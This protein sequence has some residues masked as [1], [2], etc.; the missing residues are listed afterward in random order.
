MWQEELIDA[1]SASLGDIGHVR[2]LFLVGSHGKGAADAFSDIDLL[3]IVEE[4]RKADFVSAWR[5]TL[6]NVTSI[7]F[8]NQRQADGILINAITAD[9]IRCDLVIP[10]GT[11]LHGR[12]R[13]TVRVLIDRDDLYGTLPAHLSHSG[14]NA[15][16]VK[17]LINE[18]IRVLGL[19][20]V[21][22]GRGEY[23]TGVAGAGMLR[24]H[25]ASLMVEESGITDPGGA[26]HLSRLLSPEQMEILLGLPYPGPERASVVEAHLRTAQAF[27]PRA[28]TMAAA[29][30][31]PWP[32]RFEEATLRHLRKAF[33]EEFDVSWQGVDALSQARSGA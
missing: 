20:V 9:W 15:D 4:D 3:A 24:D 2:G 1:V 11:T 10:N 5:T 33:G 6:E 22:V 13:D 31:I 7:V 21:V 17:Y 26:L 29:L 30:D 18:F 25:L 16:R 19:M 28:Q 27:M 8:W 12:S 23:F 32:Q 14:P